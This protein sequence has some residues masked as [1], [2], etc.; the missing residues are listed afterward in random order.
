MLSPALR[1]KTVARPLFGLQWVVGA[2][3][4]SDYDICSLRDRSWVC[5]HWCC[6]DRCRSMP[7]RR[8][9]LRFRNRYDSYQPRL[10]KQSFYRYPRH[11]TDPKHVK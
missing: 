5:R 7:Q 9:S 2:T 3:R 4:G 8:T 10:G 6:Q 11:P 1:K